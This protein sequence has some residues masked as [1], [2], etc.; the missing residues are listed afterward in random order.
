VEV[1]DPAMTLRDQSCCE[2]VET[3]PALLRPSDSV[4]LVDYGWVTVGWVERETKRVLLEVLVSAT[5]MVALPR[6]VKVLRQTRWEEKLAATILELPVP[7]ARYPRARG[8]VW[9]IATKVKSDRNA[10]LLHDIGCWL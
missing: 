9:W 3:L 1:E 6:H 5:A 2:V 8:L 7:E 4:W 10:N